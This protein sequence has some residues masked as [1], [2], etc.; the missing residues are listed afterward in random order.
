[1]VA[2]SFRDANMMANVEKALT[3]GMSTRHTD[4]PTVQ[5]SAEGGA[6]EGV[7]KALT[8]GMSAR[9][10]DESTVQQSAEGGAAVAATPSESATPAV[11]SPPPSPPEGGVSPPSME[12]S[13]PAPARS[14]SPSS[15]SA[16]AE[17]EARDVRVSVPMTDAGAAVAQPSNSNAPSDLS[18]LRR[19]DMG[20]PPYSVGSMAS[21]GSGVGEYSRESSR[22][23]PVLP[24]PGAFLDVTRPCEISIE[25]SLSSGGGTAHGARQAAESEGKVIVMVGWAHAMHSLLM[26]LD[27]HL[28]SGSEVFVLSEK[29]LHWRRAALAAD[30]MALDGSVL[31]EGDGLGVPAQLSSPR[32]APRASSQRSFGSTSSSP[33]ALDLVVSYGGVGLTNV[34][35][36]HIVGFCTDV[37]ALRRLPIDRA[38]AAI[39]SADGDAQDAAI[40]DSEVMSS[41]L[42]LRTRHVTTEGASPNPASPKVAE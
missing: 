19:L 41:A 31:A 29:P 40:N 16:G 42:I 1:M 17:L 32:A 5:Q 4:E 23:A 34:R 10:T 11:A 2:N 39:V 37:S 15:L 27:G 3:K 26:A 38:V 9:H 12:S 20:R 21:V 7:W 14:S 36:V 33:R 8:K 30:G 28:P 18:L 35:L 6:A 22:G 24:Q 25:A 13:A